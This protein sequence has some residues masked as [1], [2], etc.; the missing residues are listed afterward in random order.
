[1]VVPP[2]LLLLVGASGCRVASFGLPEVRWW[3]FCVAVFDVVSFHL[4]S[5][6]L[7]GGQVYWRGVVRSPCV[8]MLT[9]FLSA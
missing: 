6:L 8:I 7:A 9:T 3:R 5:C 2:L 1:M 4:W